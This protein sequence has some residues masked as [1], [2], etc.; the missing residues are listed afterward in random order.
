MKIIVDNISIDNIKKSEAIIVGIFY[1]IIKKK[2]NLEIPNSVKLIEEI[3]GI[4]LGSDYLDL[5]PKNFLNYIIIHPFKLQNPKSIILLN[6]G[7]S[8]K[9][10]E[11]KIREIGCV[12]L[13]I[14]KTLKYKSISILFKFKNLYKIKN[15]MQMLSE[16]IFL[17]NYT[18]DKY[19]SKKNIE[20]LKVLNILIKNPK[21]EDVKLINKGQLI[22]KNI[23]IARDLINEPAENLTPKKFSQLSIISA[24]NLPLIVDVFNY[25]DLKKNNFNL[26][27][28]VDRASSKN[29]EACIIRFKY[30]PENFLKKKH[31]CLVGK[32]VTFDSGGLDLKPPSSMISMKSDMSGA[33]A[34]F[35][36]MLNIAQLK[37]DVKVTGYLVC[38]ENCIGS[39]SYHPGDI[40]ISKKGLS[41]EIENTDA[42][43]RLLLADTLTFAQSE[44]QID[45]LIDIATLT[46]ACKVALGPNTAGIFSNNKKLISHI[47]KISKSSG[48]SF[49][50]MPLN[51]D[52]FYQLKSDVA[53]IKNCGT[54]F[55]G[56]ITAGL[57][58]QKFIDNKNIWCHIDIA[59]AAFSDKK[60]SYK[61]KGG[62]GFGIR[63][64][65]DFILK[66][67]NII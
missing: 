58:L 9:L 28:A 22:A 17:G 43:G 15:Y 52:L 24:K 44:E 12:C 49:W 11:D 27:L 40:I 48:E 18:F 54:H 23:N 4:N 25:K 3:L 57:F 37:P 60:K 5:F 67:P 33:A 65:T 21:I 8:Y 1:N 66:N 41:V 50:H 61:P 31:I 38:V 7:N 26:I 39:N 63:T 47:C 53:D 45:V 56:A 10:K 19:K 14:G 42:E 55:G 59:G 20:K 29:K 32:G 36:T 64:L 46:G 2:Y 62:I 30:I 13:E 51:D 35:S 16:G 6:L 34:V